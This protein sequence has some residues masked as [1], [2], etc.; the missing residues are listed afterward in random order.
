M[1][2]CRAAESATTTSD[3][4]AAPPRSQLHSEGKGERDDYIERT[5]AAVRKQIGYVG[6]D[7]SRR[8]V[9]AELTKALRL[10][11]DRDGE[12][13][14]RRRNGNTAAAS[15]VLDDGYSIEFQSFEH[16]AQPGKL[17]DQL[18]TTVGIATEFSKL[19]ARR[20]A[21]LVRRAASRSEELRDREV[22][23]DEAVRLLGSRS[24]SSST[25]GTGPRAGASGRGWMGSTPS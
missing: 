5:I 10:S 22:Y 24:R 18:S 6:A 1:L 16:V 11:K 4:S 13:D 2:G 15:I 17:G 20:V 9:L 14:A 12:S 7:A 19:Q 3:R 25:S 21:T 23:V 8:S